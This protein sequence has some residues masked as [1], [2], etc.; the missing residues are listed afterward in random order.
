MLMMGDEVSVM[1]AFDGC[2][3]DAIHGSHRVIA[4]RG[5]LGGHR[6]LDQWMQ[7]PGAGLRHIPDIVPLFCLSFPPYPVTLFF[8]LFHSHFHFTL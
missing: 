3:L 6:G 5:G 1:D 8:I 2:F 4:E 7:G